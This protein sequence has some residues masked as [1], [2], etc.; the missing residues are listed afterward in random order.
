MS[1]RMTVGPLVF[2]S[3]ACPAFPRERSSRVSAALSLSV[4]LASGLFKRVTRK[5]T[6]AG[7]AA[8]KAFFTSW[9]ILG[10]SGV[11]RVP[12]Y[13]HGVRVLSVF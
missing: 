4:S 12:L 3:M 8:S 10:P 11:S 2:S 7:V 1:T 13:S 6:A 9:G 5:A